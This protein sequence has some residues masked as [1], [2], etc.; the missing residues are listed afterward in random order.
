MAWTA[1]SVEFYSNVAT[2]SGGGVWTNTSLEFFTTC[3][4]QNNQA[5]F[6]G[7]IAA[8]VSTVTDNA[9]CYFNLNE[10]T[11]TTGGG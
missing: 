11:M 10:A 7:G 5:G 1:T 8:L 6:G 3:T 4:V 9:G 2:T